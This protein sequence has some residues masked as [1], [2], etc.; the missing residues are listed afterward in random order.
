MTGVT[1]EKL[2][3]RIDSDVRITLAQLFDPFSSVHSGEFESTLSQTVQN[4]LPSSRARIE[5][6]V[7]ICVRLRELG[8]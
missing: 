2:V 5:D 1:Y 4:I 6:M 3:R 8:R 7:N